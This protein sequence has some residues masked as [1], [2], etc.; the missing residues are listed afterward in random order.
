[1]LLFRASR[2][3][4][5]FDYES[6]WNELRQ[7][8]VGGLTSLNFN[9]CDLLPIYHKVTQLVSNSCDGTNDIKV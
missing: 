5:V 2:K 9:H 1:M 8:Q 7:M 6:A 4:K 3:R